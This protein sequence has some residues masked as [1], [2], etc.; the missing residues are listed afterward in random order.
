M[1]SAP[2]CSCPAIVSVRGSV[3]SFIPKYIELYVEQIE[4]PIEELGPMRN[5]IITKLL[6]R[7]PVFG[8]MYEKVN[9]Q[10]VL[11]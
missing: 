8:Q 6:E 3:P 2:E 10:P 9:E 7:G 1:Y 5:M 11:L 4:I